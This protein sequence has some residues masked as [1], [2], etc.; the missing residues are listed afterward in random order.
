MYRVLITPLEQVGKFSDIFSIL[1]KED[2]EVVKSPYPHPVEEKD[3]LEIIPEID[4][5]ITGS[6]E[7]TVK[8]I[9]AADKLK[10]ISKYGAGVEKIDVEAATKKGIVVTYAPNQ[11]GVA[12]LTFGLMLCLARRICEANALVKAGEWTRVTGVNVWQKTLGVIGA[13]RIGQAVIRRA[14]GFEMKVLVYDVYKDEKVA[15]EL[16]FK[17]T[18]LDRLLKESDFVTIHVPLNNKTKGLIGEKEIELMKSSA[19]LINTARGGIVNEKTLYLA[20]RKKGLTGAALDAHMKEPPSKE[21]PLLSLDNVIVT[22]HMGADSQETLKNMDL[23]A[24]KNILR[25]LKGQ[26]PLYA[27]NFPFT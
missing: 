3:L 6:D 18:S 17:Y 13:G 19:Y 9:Q 26:E 27:L 15:E 23:V 2:C 7:F 16:G 24:V 20:L 25:V 5:V 22:P 11:N 4:A 12:D 21:N 14:R 10:V 1:K 8:V